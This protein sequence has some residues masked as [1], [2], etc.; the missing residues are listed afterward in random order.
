[1]KKLLFVLLVITLAVSPLVVFTLV[2]QGKSEGGGE[3]KIAFTSL[4]D[5]NEEIYVMNADGSDQTRLTYNPPYGNGCPC[6][7]PDGTK[8]AFASKR[9]GDY[10]IYVMNADGSNQ[11]RLTN[12]GGLYPCFSPDGTK[13]AF[14]SK[15]DRDYEIYVMNA[16]GSD[17]TN[18]T[19]NPGGDY[20]PSWGP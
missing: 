15:R 19:N 7:S 16:D 11:T 17:Q 10:E 3:G 9:D 4:R 8:I 20:S 12:N 1:M 13:I 5:G 2:T 18:I 6:F 14:V